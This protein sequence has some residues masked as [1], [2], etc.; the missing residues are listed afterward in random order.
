MSRT[1]GVLLK[2]F[3]WW[4]GEF[5]VLCISL[6]KRPFCWIILILGKSLT[7][8]LNTKGDKSKVIT[9]A[10]TNRVRNFHISNKVIALYN[11]INFHTASKMYCL[12][13]CGATAFKKKFW[14][15]DKYWGFDADSSWWGSTSDEESLKEDWAQVR[16]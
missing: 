8:L 9:A 15:S 5:K 11:N 7:A 4:M 3:I 13:F 1:D 10:R 6:T 2:I 12:E 16:L 14:Y